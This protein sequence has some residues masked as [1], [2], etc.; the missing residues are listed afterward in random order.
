MTNPARPGRLAP[1][2]VVDGT[3]GDLNLS[4]SMT[5]LV[6]T[7]ALFM[8]MM[9]SAEIGRRVGRA[10]LARD[11]DGLE[12]GSGS[13]EGAMFALLGLLI[14]FT[15]AGAHS[16]FED[17]RHLITAE[18]N[19]I[20]TAYLRVD[21]L[22]AD[23]QPAMRELLGHYLDARLA[24][25]EQPNDASL[26]RERV[27]VAAGLQTEIWNLATSAS[28][29]EG[30]RPPVAQLLLPALNEMI[31]ITTTRA[32]ATQNH[33]PPAIFVLL[34]TL[35]L[36][37]ALLVGYGTS[38]N[39]RR[40]W[41]HTVIFALILSMTTYVIIDLEFPRLGLIRVDSAD[42]VLFDLRESMR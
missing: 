17:R 12:K 6:F 34:V 16:R 13:A 9:A 11:P 31:D 37:G 20:G 39:R 22:P 15:F 24:A 21:L 2:P 36:I 29:R 40:G 18:A 32:M 33:P 7:T 42:R 14:A 23:A 1:K 41:L 26:T 27:A 38:P 25:F 30:M 10:R 5:A 28:M 4:E 3:S 8:A 19:A 35:C